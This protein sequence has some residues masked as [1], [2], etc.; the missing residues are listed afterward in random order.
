MKIFKKINAYEYA[1]YIA[2]QML[3]IIEEEIEELKK[4]EKLNENL[5]A[6]KLGEKNIYKDFLRMLDYTTYKGLFW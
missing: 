6:Y 1:K 3:S 5:L 2:E 4:K